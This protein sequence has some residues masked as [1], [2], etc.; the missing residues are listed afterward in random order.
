MCRPWRRAGRRTVYSGRSR[1][2]LAP[3][4][5][6]ASVSPCPARVSRPS[7]PSPPARWPRIRACLPVPRSSPT[8]VGHG[9]KRVGRSP[10]LRRPPLPRLG[11]P[12]LFRSSPT[13]S[14]EFC[15]LAPAGPLDHGSTLPSRV[16][17]NRA[18]VD[19]Q[20]VMSPL[21]ASAPYPRAKDAQA[22]VD[23]RGHRWCLPLTPWGRTD[24]PASCSGPEALVAHARGR[25]TR[26]G[27]NIP[28]SGDVTTG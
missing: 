11:V 10:F 20:T 16:T 12:P 22:R 21:I 8:P 7:W 5:A 1:H 18:T 15:A 24:P 19:A 2:P 6:T 23:S 4:G 17:G 25:S 3:G 26:G 27:L 13:S 28:N 9:S 14:L